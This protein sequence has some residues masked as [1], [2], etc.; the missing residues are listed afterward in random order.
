MKRN[1]GNDAGGGGGDVTEEVALALRPCDF[2]F[3][4]ALA[5]VVDGDTGLEAERVDDAE[6]RRVV[7]VSI[8]SWGG[9]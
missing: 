8:V 5:L 3:A 4:F 9:V 2:A 6:R 7:R 1:G